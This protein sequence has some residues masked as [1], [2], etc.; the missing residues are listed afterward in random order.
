M[1]IKTKAELQRYIDEIVRRGIHYAVFDVDGTLSYTNSVMI[2][3]QMLKYSN[4]NTLSLVIKQVYL[5][6]SLP[7][8]LLLDCIDRD[9]FQRAF[10][11]K[12][13]QFHYEVLRKWCRKYFN[14]IALKRMI[15]KTQ[16]FLEMCKK[17]GLEVHILSLSIDLVTQQYG[18]YYHAQTHALRTH[19][20]RGKCSVDFSELQNFKENYVRQFPSEQLLVVADSK[21]DLPMLQYAIESIVVGSKQRKWM[22]ELRRMIIMDTSMAVKEEKLCRLKQKCD[23]E[24]RLSEKWARKVADISRDSSKKQTKTVLGAIQY[25]KFMFFGLGAMIVNTTES[26]KR[27][28]KM[29]RI[30][31]CEINQ[32]ASDINELMTGGNQIEYFS[33]DFTYKANI[34]QKCLTNLKQIFGDA[35][36][37][38]LKQFDCLGHLESI[39]GD[40]YF[41]ENVKSVDLKNLKFVGGKIYMCSRQFDTLEDFLLRREKSDVL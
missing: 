25:V 15:P 13:D 7:Y 32:I 31:G 41:S 3:H 22:S 23:N 6:F 20:I 38:A 10:M 29:R 40:V 11:K 9:L 18:D 12:F 1:E 37:E 30:L 8:Y 39:W 26:H 28:K 33:D 16:I 2:Y 4:Q 21:H 36:L 34:D 19:N 35:H 17:A 24:K 5:A 27:K 14:E